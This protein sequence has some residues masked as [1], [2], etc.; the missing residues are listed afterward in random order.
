MSG[1]VTVRIN[2]SLLELGSFP[3]RVLES[4]VEGLLSALKGY[5]TSGDIE[6]SIRR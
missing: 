6:I 4:T 1:N 5:E 3:G 2:G